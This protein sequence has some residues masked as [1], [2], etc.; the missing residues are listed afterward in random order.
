MQMSRTNKWAGL[1]Y[2]LCL[3]VLFGALCFCT[4]SSNG[5]EEHFYGIANDGAIEE[6]VVETPDT[7]EQPVPFNLLE[8]KPQFNGQGANEF[9]K[10]VSENLVYP[11]SAKS[12]GIQGRVMVS[13]IVN[14]KGKVTDVKVLKGADESLDAEAL[15]VVSQSPDWTPGKKDGKNVPVTY[16]FPVIF[17]MK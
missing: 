2:I 1:G 4:N 13:F 17:T 11:E 7:D 6:L 9:A 16:T 15:R 5:T 12:A 10:W 3:P 8:D 14:A